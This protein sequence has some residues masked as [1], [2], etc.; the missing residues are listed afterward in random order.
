M[1]TDLIRRC[2]K[3][4]FDWAGRPGFSA[5]IYR[6][7]REDKFSKLFDTVVQVMHSLALVLLLLVLTMSICDHRPNP[8]T[9]HTSRALSLRFLAGA[10]FSLSP[11][12]RFRSS[13]SFLYRSS[14]AS[15]STTSFFVACSYNYLAVSFKYGVTAG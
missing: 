3:I 8:E 5:L 13:I 12:R 15:V 1:N 9:L 11:K 7:A 4:Q 14:S 6:L 10:S 2:V